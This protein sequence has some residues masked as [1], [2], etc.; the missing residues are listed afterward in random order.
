MSQ[1]T[2]A[3]REQQQEQG[4]AAA[5]EEEEEEEE[6][7]GVTLQPPPRR[8][9]GVHVP[10]PLRLPPQ[11]GAM[12]PITPRTRSALISSQMQSEYGLYIGAALLVA[13]VAWTLSQGSLFAPRSPQHTAA[14]EAIGAL[15][16]AAGREACG[17]CSGGGCYPTMAALQEKVG[18][19]GEWG[20]LQ[21]SLGEANGGVGW[22]GGGSGLAPSYVSVWCSLRGVLVWGVGGLWSLLLSA[23]GYLVG[24]GAWCV[25]EGTRYALAS[26]LQALQVA[27]CVG[28]VC[29]AVQCYL[30]H[31]RAKRREVLREDLFDFCADV[32]LQA[33]PPMMPLLELRD[34]A[35]SD[36]ARRLDVPREALAA[37]WPEVERQLREDRQ[38]LVCN[39]DRGGRGIPE[40]CIECKSPQGLRA[41]LQTG[42]KQRAASRERLRAQYS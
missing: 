8:I 41:G 40:A 9:A 38:Y 19:K 30:S 31:R 23:L 25:A 26:P 37:L 27:A 35:C 29:G 17:L 16:S 22:E 2:Q 6:D 1:L 7:G 11:A 10:T 14:Q 24:G 39:A 21:D 32:L 33:T 13:L 42:I 20:S 4:A 34:M 15:R 18:W 3:L 36:L 12:P 5:E 28:V